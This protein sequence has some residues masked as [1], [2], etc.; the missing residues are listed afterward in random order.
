MH[1]DVR[2]RFLM[3]CITLSREPLKLRLWLRQALLTLIVRR[4]VETR[5]MIREKSKTARVGMN[6][7][8][9]RSRWGKRVSLLVVLRAATRNC[10]LE[11]GNL[12]MTETI[13]TRESRAKD[14]RSRAMR[15][16]A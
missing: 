10:S 12:N 3:A 14:E 9:E 1:T 13:P 15:L 5:G 7:K 8:G 2:T 4:G 11:E 6:E 16:K